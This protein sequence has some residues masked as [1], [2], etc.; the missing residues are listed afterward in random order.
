MPDLALTSPASFTLPAFL[1]A[2]R[3]HTSPIEAEDSAVV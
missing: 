3:T 2:N 1:G